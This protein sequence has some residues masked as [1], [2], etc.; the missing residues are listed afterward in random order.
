MK[1]E[2][3]LRRLVNFYV[4]V[5][6]QVSCNDLGVIRLRHPLINKDCYYTSVKQLYDMTFGNCEL[7]PDINGYDFFV[8]NL[9]GSVVPE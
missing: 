3:M 1:K 2:Y 4:R 5:G 6:V 7:N 8:L 9:D